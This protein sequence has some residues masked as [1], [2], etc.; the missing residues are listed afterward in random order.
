MAGRCLKGRQII[1]LMD[2]FF[3]T[4]PHMGALYSVMD[5]VQV[6]FHGDSKMADFRYAWDTILDGM[7][8]RLA[9]DVLEK[10]LAEKLSSSTALKGDLEHYYR[11]EKDHADKNYAFLRRAMDRYLER[12]QQEKNR[13]DTRQMWKNK[14]F[15]P[16]QLSAPALDKAAPAKAKAKTKDGRDRSPTP[17]AGKAKGKSG[18]KGDASQH[19]AKATDGAGQ[20]FCWFFHHTPDGCR[21]GKDCLFPHQAPKKEVLEAMYFWLKCR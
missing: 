7:P 13:E 21:R 14:A 12:K 3:R 17:S 6:S 19:I 15:Q 20:M 2:Q 10:L 18:G 16:L 5:L 8:Q 4:Q 9:D 1:H 11:I